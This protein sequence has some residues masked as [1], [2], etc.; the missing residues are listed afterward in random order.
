MRRNSASR[1]VQDAELEPGACLSVTTYSVAVQPAAPAAFD[2][3]CRGEP[4][5]PV[6]ARAGLPVRCALPALPALRDES[7]RADDRSRKRSRLREAETG[8]RTRRRHAD[9]TIHR[10]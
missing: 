8:R 5:L 3:R 9:D 2:A 4:E 1:N 7:P 6:V 10:Q